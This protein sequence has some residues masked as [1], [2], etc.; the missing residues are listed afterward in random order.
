VGLI[1]TWAVKR[2]ASVLRGR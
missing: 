1:L 2:Y